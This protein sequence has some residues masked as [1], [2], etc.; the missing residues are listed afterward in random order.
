MRNRSY[1]GLFRV[2]LIAI[3]GM[4]RSCLCPL[5]TCFRG[6]SI[7]TLNSFA[8]QFIIINVQTCHSVSLPGLRITKSC[9]K[10]SIPLSHRFEAVENI[11][12]GVG[13][14]EIVDITPVVDINTAQVLAPTASIAIDVEVVE[15][16]NEHNQDTRQRTSTDKPPSPPS[17]FPVLEKANRLL[18]ESCHS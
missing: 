8:M 18:E 3:P 17:S 1:L 9:L 4:S 12:L 11:S 15:K 7:L 6:L 14:A 5:F 10:F 16:Q 13:G 2:F